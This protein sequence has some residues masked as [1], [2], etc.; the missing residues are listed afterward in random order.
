MAAPL[1]A[2]AAMAPDGTLKVWTM[3]TH[4][5]AVWQVVEKQITGETRRWNERAGWRVV[6]VE[7]RVKEDGNGNAVS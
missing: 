6:Q 2:W 4:S 7:I 3:R 5:A 1:L